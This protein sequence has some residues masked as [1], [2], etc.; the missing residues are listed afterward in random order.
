MPRMT[1]LHDALRGAGHRTRPAAGCGADSAAGGV[2][3]VGGGGPL[4]GEVLAQLVGSGAWARVA[5]LTDQAMAVALRGLEAWP[6]AW[7]RAPSAAGQ[8]GPPWPP[9]IAVVVFDRERSHN[10]REVALHRPTPEGLP[11]LAAVLQALGVL[12]LVLVLPHAPGLLPQALRAGLASL[13]EQ[14]VAALG[15]QQLVLVRPAYQTRGSAAGRAPG[16]LPR[17][18]HAVLAQLHW[19]V[20]QRQQALRPAQVARFVADLAQRL[21]SMGPG[22]RVVPPE[23][24]WD[25]AHPTG[26]K[27][28]AVSSQ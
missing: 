14:A 4:G 19:M 20:P 10:R 27:R 16:L 17:V 13:D 11:A 5:V 21:P 18:A 9:D 1:S 28:R 8:P 6:L 23:A 26:P 22:T 24:V 7:L 3:V 15:F 12:H 25:W 2:L